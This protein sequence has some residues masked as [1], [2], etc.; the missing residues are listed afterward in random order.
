MFQSRNDTA[1]D[2]LQTRTCTRRMVPLLIG[3]AVMLCSSTPSL[4]QTFRQ[5]LEQRWTVSY[6]LT[7]MELNNSAMRRTWPTDDH[8]LIWQTDSGP[9]DVVIRRTEALAGYLKSMP[10]T[11]SLSDLES[12]LAG[13]KAQAPGRRGDIALFKEVCAVRREIALRNPLLDFDSLLFCAHGTD[14][15]RQMTHTEPYPLGK[16]HGSG[17]FAVADYKTQSPR[18]IDLLEHARVTNGPRAGKILSNA[19]AEWGGTASVHS[20]TLSFDADTVAFSWAHATTV[21]WC[22][23]SQLPHEQ[24]EI[25]KMALDGSG[26]VQL[27]DSAWGNYDPCFLP[28]GRIVFVSG[29]M[30]MGQRCGDDKH[31]CGVL[32]SM[33]GDGSDVV[34]L[35]WHETNDRL[36]FLDNDGSLVYTRWDYIDRTAYEGQGLFRC[37]PDGR[38]PRSPHGNYATDDKPFHPIGEFGIRPIVPGGAF[39]GRYVAIDAG[40]H[41]GYYGNVIVIDINKRAKYDNQIRWFWPVSRL[42]GD[43]GSVDEVKVRTD[44]G[45]FGKRAFN[46]PWP[47][48]EDFVMVGE[49]SELL[50]LDKF[51]NEVLLYDV[52]PLHDSAWAR[53][54]TPVKRREPPPIPATLTYQ[55]ER[56]G[57]PEMQKATISVM[58]VYE[59]DFEWPPGTKITHLRIAQVIPKPS[60]RW[61]EPVADIGYRNEPAIGWSEGAMVR[62]VLGTVPVEDDGSAY[63]YAPIEREIYFQAL[64]SSGHAVQSMLSAT[65]VHP[66]EQMT[67]VGCHEDKW[68]APSPGSFGTPRALRR[69]PSAITPEPSGSFPFSYY[70]LVKEPVFDRRCLPC[71]Q[72]EGKGIDFEY[73]DFSEPLC[74][75]NGTH[76][77][78][79][80]LERFCRYYN[81][82]FP[83]AGFCNNVNSI[84]AARAEAGNVGALSCSLLTYLQPSHHG[85][86]L[87]EEEYRRAVLWMD[88]NCVELGT[89]D[90]KMADVT[91]AGD[92][93]WLTWPYASVDRDN[94]SGVQLDG[95]TVGAVPGNRPAPP[96]RAVRVRTAGDRIVVAN[97]PDGRGRIAVHSLDGRR[98]VMQEYRS[99]RPDG[100][101]RVPM[102]GIAPGTYVVRISG[103]Q[104]RLAA[105]VQSVVVR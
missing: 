84:N 22:G 51:R 6:E 67:C 12:Q 98:A 102:R 27:T 72:K 42:R 65:Y 83:W 93:V 97:L 56:R 9:V 57:D 1:D 34:A 40:H 66:G 46:I 70:R 7:Q 71:H 16:P 95:G 47:L 99:A 73:W 48:S 101:A 3:V 103:E 36:P 89:Y 94:P 13:L 90:I 5:L 100:V 20:P 17:L 82:A 91:R 25:F 63:F 68:M 87:T 32:H 74:D 78:A 35:S 96:P 10:N 31:I 85:V 76:P 2:S 77:R 26:L 64:D 105:P 30:G 104:G 79:G 75:K 33:K 11:P 52:E 4:S 8:A 58:N 21:S 23:G 45:Y 29:R 49:F 62:W 50:L 41:S 55:G 38:D 43:N 18:L 53:W 14:N 44:P 15:G 69:P 88:M 19:N 28:N 92:E 54:P 61:A 80:E 37:F 81:A 24:Y 39:T 59:A 86:D 60:R